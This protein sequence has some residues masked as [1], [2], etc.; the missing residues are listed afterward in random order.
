ML[1]VPLDALTVT[2]TAGSVIVRAVVVTPKPE[3]AMRAM[4]AFEEEP[5]RLSVALA[6]P[7][8][9]VDRPQVSEVAYDPG[10]APPQRAPP[11]PASAKLSG[12]D[13]AGVAV[14]QTATAEWQMAAIAGVG[15]IIITIAACVALYRGG[16]CA[17]CRDGRISSYEH[18]RSSR[19]LYECRDRSDGPLR[20]AQSTKSGLPL[21]SSAHETGAGPPQH[22]LYAAT[23]LPGGGPYGG[24][25]GSTKSARMPASNG[26]STKSGKRQTEDFS[27]VSLVTRGRGPSAWSS[28]D[29]VAGGIRPLASSKI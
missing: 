11:P 10:A 6:I 21:Y 3:L 27:G 20:G 26:R 1:Q 29:S 4:T 19:R 2:A 9:A 25:G 16:V 22:S 24:P 5:A 23:I 12:D 13:S 14:V 7:V 8:T 17:R 28:H 15:V 18:R